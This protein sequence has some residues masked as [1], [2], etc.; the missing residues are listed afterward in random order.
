MVSRFFRWAAALFLICVPALSADES[1]TAGTA[2]ELSAV[3][4]SRL[5]E[6]LGEAG[7]AER[8]DATQKLSEMGA[9]ACEQLEQAII[10]GSREVS[11]RA[12]GI[13]RQQWEGT[14]DD[15]KQAAGEAL[16]RLAQS[17]IV[18]LAQR[19]RNALGTL[20]P[21]PASVPF[22]ALPANV[23]PMQLGGIGGL[24]GIVRRISISREANGTRSLEILE[25][26]RRTK[27][28]AAPGGQ[29]TL[30]VTEKRNGRDVT[31]SMQAKDL[32]ELRRLDPA[33]AQLFEHLDRPPAVRIG[34]LPNW[35]QLGIPDA[36]P[37]MPV[38]PAIEQFR[39][40]RP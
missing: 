7:F 33:A 13:L 5:I 15:A 22:G 32:D 1:I 20:P 27:V 39:P 30:E 3:E 18:T 35:R 21:A 36:G 6:R 40:R 34:A 19:A 24:G 10:R 37:V 4:I 26:D 25:N 23:M 29:I 28:Q 16:Q 2:D 14:D 9:A 8:Q 31:R 11:G 17:E 12:L 38:V